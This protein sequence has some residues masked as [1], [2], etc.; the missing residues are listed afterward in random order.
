MLLAMTDDGSVTPS[1]TEAFLEDATGA[2]AEP[3]VRYEGG[4]LACGTRFESDTERRVRELVAAHTC[5]SAPG[6][7]PT[8]PHTASMMQPVSGALSTQAAPRADSAEFVANRRQVATIVA[9]LRAWQRTLSRA[10]ERDEVDLLA[11]AERAGAQLD[12]DEVADLIELVEL[13]YKDERAKTVPAA[14]S[15]PP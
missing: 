3:A 15:P 4:C 8:R 7:A 6:A 1:A 9:A 5:A 12:P 14:F 11:A 2:A 13:V 10:P